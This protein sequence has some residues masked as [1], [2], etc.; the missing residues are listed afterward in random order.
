M[1]QLANIVSVLHR[2][3]VDGVK[4]AFPKAMTTAEKSG[5]YDKVFALYAAVQQRPRIKAYLESP[6]RQKYSLGI[7]RYYE[8]LDFDLEE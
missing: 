1:I 4:F 6:R 5:K 8:E 3:C 7:Y 2:Q